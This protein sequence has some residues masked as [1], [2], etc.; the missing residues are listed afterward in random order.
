[1][2]TFKK[3]C[4]TGPIRFG[5]SSVSC[6]FSVTPVDSQTSKKFLLQVRKVFFVCIE[7]LILHQ[8]QDKI[9]M[10]HAHASHIYRSHEAN[11]TVYAIWT[12]ASLPLVLYVISLSGM[13]RYYTLRF[14]TFTS[15]LY[16]PRKQDPLEKP[17]DAI[18]TL[19]EPFS[20]YDTER[21]PDSP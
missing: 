18:S 21:L 19:H 14:S 15:S 20:T 7:Y 11:S 12:K 2:V 1:M 13:L 6:F 17:W 10:E 3:I 8:Y 9:R 5:E 4:A 16:T